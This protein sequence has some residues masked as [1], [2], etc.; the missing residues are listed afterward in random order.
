MLVCS[1]IMW[2]KKYKP[3][4]PSRR[5]IVGYTFDEITKT[6]PEKSLVR[7]LSPASG[8]NNTGRTT[9]RFKGGRHKRLYRTLDRK[10]Y[11]KLDIPGKIAS[12]EYDPFRTA[13]IVLIHYRDGEKRYLLARKGVKVGDEIMNG[14]TAPIVAG[15]RKQ[16][17]D[18]PDGLT[19][20]NIEFTPFTKGKIVKSAG[21]FATITGREET[22]N[23]VFL[24]L[25]SGEVRKFN[26]AC[27]GTIGQVGNEEHKNIV[28]GKA[29]RQRWKGKKPHILGKSMNA[30][31]H[32]HG[33]GEWHSSLGLK[34]PKS[35][36]GKVVAPGMKT[37]KTKKWSNSLIIS[38][39][40]KK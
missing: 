18:I 38:R 27:W 14:T 24:K 16:L 40:K 3:Y 35:F 21:A 4:T 25:P 8:R 37:R 30:V 12:V 7:W 6:K 26:G 15:N 19:V 17:Q 29:W 39:R 11:D 31:D 33:W 36:T 22:K 28:I 2:I 5:Y 9:S 34:Y 23:V 20:F 10:G 1:G 13:R 32:P